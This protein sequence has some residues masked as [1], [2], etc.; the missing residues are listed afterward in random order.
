MNIQKWFDELNDQHQSGNLDR[1]DFLGRLAAF[2]GSCGVA[3]A[4]LTVSAPAARAQGGKLRFDG[5]GGFS[6]E[7]FDRRVLQVFAAETGAEVSQGSYSNPDQFLAQIQAEGVENYNVFWSGQELAPIKVARRG[8]AE[9]I[10]EAKIP[11]LADLLQ[12]PLENNR[13]QGGGGLVSVPYTLSGGAIAY[14]T[15]MISEEEMNEKGFSILI[16]AAHAGSISGFDN[17]QYRL[18]Y[19]ALQDGQDPNAIE[20]MDAVWAKV[21]ESKHSVLKYYTSGAEQVSLLTSREVAVTDGWFVPIHNLR[22]R[23][24]PIGFWPPQGSYVQS[25]GLVPLKGTS[26]DL[27]YELCDVLLRPDVLFPLAIETGNLPL[28]DP[29]KHPYPEEVT[30]IPGYVPPGSD[31]KIYRFNPELWDSKSEAWSREYQR[32]MSRA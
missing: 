15:D 8:W 25:G 32:F 18:Y 10:D 28:L 20:D 24:E 26:M 3:A 7:V 14:N 19:A 31:A 27:F 2:T 4:G 17:W 13:R 29:A 22:Q 1:R 12:E 5:F 16:D 30:A 21:A 9:P 6:Q 23:G 11:R